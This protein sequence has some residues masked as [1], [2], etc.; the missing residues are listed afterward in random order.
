VPGKNGIFLPIVVRDGQV[1]GTW[2]GSRKKDRAVVSVAT[3][4]DQPLADE[5]WAEWARRYQTFQ[6]NAPK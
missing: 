3:F 1:I 2:R 5:Q 6:G 4:K